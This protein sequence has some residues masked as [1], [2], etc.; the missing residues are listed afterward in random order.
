MQA[1]HT[2]TTDLLP[3]RPHPDRATP[4]PAPPNHRRL[5][6]PMLLQAGQPAGPT[7]GPVARLPLTA[8]AGSFSGQEVHL[9]T[10]PGRW[11]ARSNAGRRGITFC[12]WAGNGTC[13]VFDYRPQLGLATVLI[14]H[15]AG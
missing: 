5:T 8:E 11:A 12:M 13:S 15:L 2:G 3:P 14:H 4:G 10:E 9:T 7:T 6:G 1:D